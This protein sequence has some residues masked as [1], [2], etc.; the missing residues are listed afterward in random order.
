M[1]LNSVI[2]RVN[3]VVVE[4]KKQIVAQIQAATAGTPVPFKLV[5]PAEPV[6]APV[7]K[8]APAPAPVVG[9]EPAPVVKVPA[10]A[11]PPK[12]PAAAPRARNTAAGSPLSGGEPE[13]TFSCK[14]AARCVT[15]HAIQK[16]YDRT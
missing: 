10:P 3:G 16:I 2:V 15:S 6:P 4:D 5:R 8:P 1:L 9:P 13:A 7:I 11:P 12:R 14:H